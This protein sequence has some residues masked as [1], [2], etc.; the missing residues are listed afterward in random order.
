[1]KDEGGFVDRQ[2][3][4]QMYICDCRIAFATEKLDC[5]FLGNISIKSF[6]VSF[7]I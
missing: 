5:L 2:T 4:R 6:L 3:N 7:E 1:M